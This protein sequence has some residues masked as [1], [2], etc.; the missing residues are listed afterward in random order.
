MEKMRGQGDAKVLLAQTTLNVDGES[1]VCNET[2][3]HVRKEG[4]T[5]Y[6]VGT[7]KRANVIC[8]PSNLH[9][10]LSLN[11]RSFVNNV[12]D[13]FL[14]SLVVLPSCGARNRDLVELNYYR[15]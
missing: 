4:S 12:T 14:Y 3:Q 15:L 2:R 9:C 5:E 7:E 11:T 10:L 1:F 6:M 8:T 13:A